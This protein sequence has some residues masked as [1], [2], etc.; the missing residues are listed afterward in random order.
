MYV[1][2]P[3]AIIPVLLGVY[4]LFKNETIEGLKHLLNANSRDNPRT[5][6][7]I[8]ENKCY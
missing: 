2:P 4:L 6:F 3:L 8:N 7:G 1:N 5:F